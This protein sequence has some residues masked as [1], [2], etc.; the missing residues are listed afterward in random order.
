VAQLLGAGVVVEDVILQDIP[1]HRQL[2]AALGSAAATLE[3]LCI[4]R[5]SGAFD[6]QE[7]K[8]R[9]VSRNFRSAL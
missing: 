6:V 5:H 7:T 4:S 1:G 9:E 3:S 8:D 2:L